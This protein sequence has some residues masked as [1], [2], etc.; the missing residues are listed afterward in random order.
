METKP[1]TMS[2]LR[3]RIHDLWRSDDF[4]SRRLAH[5][6]VAKTPDY[7]RDDLNA[8]GGAN[9]T[10]LACTPSVVRLMR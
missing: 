6:A 3:R 1:L 2:P 4:P 7:C 8:A 5:S 9:G 10:T